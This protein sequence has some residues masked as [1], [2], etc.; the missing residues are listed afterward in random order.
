MDFTEIHGHLLGWITIGAWGVLC[1]WALLER[2]LRREET[3]LFWRGVSVAQIL[4]VVQLLLGLGLL[5]AGRVPH[6]GGALTVVFHLLY[7]FGFPLVVLFFSHRWARLGRLNPHTI[8][9]VASLVIFA[10]TLRGYQVGI[11]GV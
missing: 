4:L 10:L 9:A 8:F 5:V 3:P 7:G 1:L 6:T 11:Q 2:A